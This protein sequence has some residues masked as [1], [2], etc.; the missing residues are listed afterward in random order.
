MSHEWGHAIQFRS[1][2]FD[3]VPEVPTPIVELQ[4][5]CYSGAWFGRIARGESDV[6]TFTDT[7]IRSGII[8]TV[9]S[10]DPVGFRPTDPGAHGAGFDRVSAFQDGLNQGAAQSATYVD[11]PPTITE[12]GFDE[13]EI[14]ADDPGDLPYADIID[15][16]PRGPQRLLAGEPAG[17]LRHGDRPGVHRRSARL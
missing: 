12:F 16:L 8:D 6:L 15:L 5:D 2:V 13:A 10:A 3:I 17:R 9:L 1:G 11:N 7:D 4:A 14:M